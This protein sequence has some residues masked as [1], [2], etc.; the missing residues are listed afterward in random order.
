[1]RRS[2]RLRL[3]A[4]TMG[5]IASVAGMGALPAQ[6]VDDVVARAGEY[7]ETFRRD[8]AGVVLEEKYFQ[9]ASG[10]VTLAREVRSDLAVMSDAQQGWI[11]F[12][13]VFEVDGKPVR[14][15]ENRVVE[16]FAEPRTDAL[17]Q[18]RR[19][20]AEGARF[21]LNV[22]GVQFD[23]TIN[24]PMAALM[25]LRTENQPRSR[26]LREATETLGGRRVMIVR[27]EER[28]KPRLIG[29]PDEAAARGRFWIEL[30]S[31]RV[32]RTNLELHTRRGT[33]DVAAALT[34]NFR[35]Y[36]DLALWLPSE[37]EETYEL[38]GATR[39]VLAAIG[40]RAL[41][42]NA[43]KFRVD[44]DEDVLPD[45]PAPAAP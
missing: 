44:V 8:V 1:M 32:L 26:F 13:D 7:L 37:M 25:F 3:V 30:D 31:G 38:T 36:P 4:A 11:E 40:G 43:R 21:N 45:E 5:G 27:F 42:S 19:I 16:L 39:Q 24:L 10:S 41:Y 29:T 2:H 18:A 23:R 12:R 33:T 6:G 9:L 15:R 22:V 34:V 14:D 17:E 20:V 28:E 35:D